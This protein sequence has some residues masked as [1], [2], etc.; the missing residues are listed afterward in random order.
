MFV[1]RESAALI[2]IATHGTCTY[3]HKR[4]KER[5]K[6]RENKKRI[7]KQRGEE[8]RGERERTR[9]GIIKHIQSSF[10][11]F[12]PLSFLLPLTSSSSSSFTGLMSYDDKV[13]LHSLPTKDLDH[14][15]GMR[16]GGK[17]CDERKKTIV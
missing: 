4:E 9:E 5:K 6:E 1:D 2:G 13:I 16:R 14:F 7:Q 17:H 11:V 3:I 8:K 15:E 10:S 12:F